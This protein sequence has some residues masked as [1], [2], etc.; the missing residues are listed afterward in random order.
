M[1]SRGKLG[2]GGNEPPSNDFKSPI[3]LINQ[4]RMPFQEFHN[5]PLSSKEILFGAKGLNLTLLHITYNSRNVT[6]KFTH[7]SE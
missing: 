1:K 3:I 2:G 7:K 4:K 5:T 6:N